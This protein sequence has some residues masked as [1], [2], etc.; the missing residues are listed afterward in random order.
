MNA[1]ENPCEIVIEKPLSL[2]KISLKAV[3]GVT[4]PGT[5]RQ[6]YSDSH[7]TLYQMIAAREGC[8]KSPCFHYLPLDSLLSSGSGSHTWQVSVLLLGLVPAPEL[9]VPPCSVRGSPRRNRAEAGAGRVPQPW[10]WPLTVT[11]D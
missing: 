3:W 7:G 6:S 2:K 9:G 4:L 8:V 10:P 11:P 1:I 5:H